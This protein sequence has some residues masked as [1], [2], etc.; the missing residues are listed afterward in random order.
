MT[1]KHFIKIAETLKDRAIVIEHY[2][3]GT[4]KERATALFTLKHTIYDLGAEFKLINSNFDYDKFV[5]ATEIE[6]K[7]TQ[8]WML[9]KQEIMERRIKRNRQTV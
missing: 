8:A 3:M 1:K 7:E 4:N 5:N 9:Y 2:P 6:E